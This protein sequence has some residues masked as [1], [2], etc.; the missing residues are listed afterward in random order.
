MPCC[1]TGRNIQKYKGAAASTLQDVTDNGNTTTGDIITTSGYFIGDGSKL[2]GISGASAAFTLQ[3]TSDRG[4][5]TSN[6]VQFTNPITSLTTSGNVIVVGNV[7]ASNF[8]GDGT[9]LDGVALSTD[10]VSNS[11][12]IGTVS[13]DL[14]DNST[15]IS[16]VSTDLA[17]NSTRI[18]TVSTDLADNST[19]ISTVST[20]LASNSTRIGIVS[21]DL[22]DNSTRISTVSTDLASNSTRIGIVSTDLADNSTRISTV[23]TDLASNSTRI[24]IVSTDLAD[25]ST[26]ISTVSTDLA[27]NST[28]ISTVSTDLIS[29]ASRITTLEGEIQPVNR[30]GTGLTSFVSGDLIYANGTSSFTNLASNSSTQGYFLK[31]DN[32]VPIWADVSQVGSASPYS[33]VAGTGLSGGNF[34]GSS[35]V[36]WTVDFGVV[37]TTSN[38]NSNVTRIYNLETNL[39]NNS[40]RITTITNDLTN[41]VSRI[42]NL[43]TNLT[44]NSARITT[45][46]NDLTNNVNRIGNLETNLTNNSSRIT[47]V[48]NDLTNN[49][50]RIGNLETN[51]TNNSSRITTVTNDLTNNVSR[52]STLENEVQPVNRG[53]TGLV[54]Y[55]VGDI[56]YASGTTTLSKLSIG[57][58]D[59]VLTVSEGT[60]S[61]QPASGGTGSSY[62]TQT[63]TGTD[64]YYNSGNVGIANTAPTNTLDVGEVFS[65]VNSTSG[66]DVLILRGNAYFNDELYI[67]KKLTVPASGEI[68]ADTIKCRSLSTKGTIVINERKESIVRID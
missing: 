37:A 32:G 63:G 42:G 4:N 12:R 3:E 64:I 56:L 66:G 28:R 6:V 68:L 24:G 22:A 31:N 17:S 36:P 58:D 60:V 2:T 65:V 1:D 57:S 67:A 21:T 13:T 9:T 25:N 53:G 47:T 23:S 29:N 40:A 30:G 51:L 11:T 61:W 39:N 34:N 14:A 35:E 5:T 44:N 8:Y 50:S 19:R 43:E 26:R 7:T 54:N 33:H 18:G 10:L 15:R 52:I 46:T 20:D 41:N 38:L 27:S 16:T 59:E 48:T 49:V 45:V 55:S 62:W